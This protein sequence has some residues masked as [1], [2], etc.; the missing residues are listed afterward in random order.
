[1]PTP[2]AVFVCWVHVIPSGD[3]A[4]TPPKP[5]ARKEVPLATTLVS[6]MVAPVRGVQ[7][8]PSGDVMI[9][10]V[11]APAT[12]T[13]K[14]PFQATLSRLLVTPLVRVV[15]VMPSGDVRTVPLPPTATN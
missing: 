9:R 2:V 3:V 8:T 12:A 15:Q 7:V 4:V 6:E 1:M 13:N 14:L 10:V 11:D 5:A